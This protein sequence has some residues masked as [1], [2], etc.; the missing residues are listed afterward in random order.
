MAFENEITFSFKKKG[1]KFEKNKTNSSVN[2]RN[3]QNKH[4]VNSGFEI[5]IFHFHFM[6]RANF[7]TTISTITSA[8]AVY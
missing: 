4:F 5:V 8:T 1:H 3:E 2:V 7:Y 6:D